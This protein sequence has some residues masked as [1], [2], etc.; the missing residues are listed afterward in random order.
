MYAEC[1]DEAFLERK[2]LMD[3]SIDLLSVF[4]RHEPAGWFHSQN[5]K[6]WL[7]GAFMHIFL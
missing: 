7:Q 1:V 4:A 5:C 2:L 3:L 6:N